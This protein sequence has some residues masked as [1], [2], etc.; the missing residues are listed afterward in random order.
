MGDRF[1]RYAAQ[2]W[3]QDDFDLLTDEEVRIVKMRRKQSPIDVAMQIPMSV[4]TLY[5]RERS[6]R[7]KLG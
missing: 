6:I 7:S 1:Q 5:R 3:T 2:R 4:E